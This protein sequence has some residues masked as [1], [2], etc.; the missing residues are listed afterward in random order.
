MKQKFENK[1]LVGLKVFV[2]E[3]ILSPKHKITEMWVCISNTTE[4]NLN[5]TFMAGDKIDIRISA[6]NGL[7]GTVSV[8]CRGIKV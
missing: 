4:E 6:I 2:D 8:S 3:V 5:L 7:S 1:K